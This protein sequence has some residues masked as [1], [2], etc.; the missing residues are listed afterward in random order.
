MR[1][2]SVVSHYQGEDVEVFDAIND[3]DG[4]C[5]GF[6]KKLKNTETEDFPF[7]AF[8][9]VNEHKEIKLV[10]SVFGTHPMNRS[11]MAEQ[12]SKNRICAVEIDLFEH[13]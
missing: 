2:Y 3:V 1:D 13:V 9:Y 12:V 7:M 4:L 6:V 11:R 10:D 5:I 8:V